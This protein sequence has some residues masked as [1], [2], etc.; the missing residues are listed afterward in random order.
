MVLEV[1]QP[2]ASVKFGR[3]ICTYSYIRESTF[4]N[5]IDCKPL[6][7][8]IAK[9]TSIPPYLSSVLSSVTSKFANIFQSFGWAPR[10]IV[11][12]EE[13]SIFFGIEIVILH[14]RR[15][16]EGLLLLISLQ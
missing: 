5:D 1:V 7:S 12:T 4:V 9:Q 2:A 3:D 10:A 14:F 15:N 8:P 11:G 6:Y 16:L 13:D